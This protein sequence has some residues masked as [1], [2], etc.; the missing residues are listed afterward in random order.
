MSDGVRK[1]M[2]D[3]GW[4]EAGRNEAVPEECLVDNDGYVS[5]IGCGGSVSYDTRY[6][7]RTCET[8]HPRPPPP[9]TF[10]TRTIRRLDE[11]EARLALLDTDTRG[12]Q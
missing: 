1:Y 9:E 4:V 8:C 11:L 5:H 10:Y 12:E 3:R 7:Y 2:T 6:G